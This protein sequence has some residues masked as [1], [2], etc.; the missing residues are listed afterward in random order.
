MRWDRGQHR[1]LCTYRGTPVLLNI[2]TDSVEE[3]LSSAGQALPGVL[4]TIAGGHRSSWKSPKTVLWIAHRALSGICRRQ[5]DSG[6]H[7][8]L[9]HL[10][11]LPLA[12]SASAVFMRCGEFGQHAAAAAVGKS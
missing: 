11:P 3:K 1:T 4:V 7:G 6:T 10:C 5:L 2:D 12:S 8:H 9:L